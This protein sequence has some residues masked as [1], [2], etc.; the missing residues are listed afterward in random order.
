MTRGSSLD[1]P[2][3]P[4]HDRKTHRAIGQNLMGSALPSGKD[5]KDEAIQAPLRK[6]QDAGARPRDGDRWFDALVS[7]A[8]LGPVGRN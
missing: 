3:E 5:S 6:R 8:G 7:C 4:G 2:V 1:A